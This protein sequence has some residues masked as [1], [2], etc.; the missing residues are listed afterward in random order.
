MIGVDAVWSMVAAVVAGV[1][2]WLVGYRRKAEL[3][4]PMENNADEG[5]REPTLLLALLAVAIRQG[6]SISG[7]LAVVGEESGGAVGRCLVEAAQS[8]H[9]GVGWHEAWLTEGL[10]PADAAMVS[11]IGETLEP[12]WKHGVSPVARIE[13]MIERLDADE[14]GAIEEQAAVLSVRVLA[15]LGLCFLPSF[16]CLGIIPSVAAFMG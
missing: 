8:L 4:R 7:A 1:M 6:A 13:A 10:A 15:P 2:M 3:V 12:S 5:V 14:R 9:R 16:I 11:C